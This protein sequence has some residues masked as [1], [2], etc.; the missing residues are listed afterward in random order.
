MTE[1]G[2]RVGHCITRLRA[3]NAR[4]HCSEQ[5]T[6]VALA[7]IDYVS[8]HFRKIPTSAFGFDSA[9]NRKFVKFNF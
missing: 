2:V 8:N 6:S 1:S 5:T 3:Y 4:A 9:T 7:L